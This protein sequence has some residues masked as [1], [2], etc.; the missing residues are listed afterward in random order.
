MGNTSSTLQPNT[1]FKQYR[2]PH[3]RPGQQ[4]IPASLQNPASRHSRCSK[5]ARASGLAGTERANTHSRSTRNTPRNFA[6][7][8]G[9]AVERQRWKA[10]HLRPRFC[11]RASWSCASRSYE[12]TRTTERGTHLRFCG[13]LMWVGAPSVS[14]WGLVCVSQAILSRICTARGQIAVARSS[15][16]FPK[17]LGTSVSYGAWCES[18]AHPNSKWSQSGDTCGLRD[19]HGVERASSEE[20]GREARGFVG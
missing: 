1:Q 8:R 11:E 12:Y 2:Q 20:Q 4:T 10:A 3:T 7:L 18:A 15:E 6:A 5:Q 17:A 16:I 9:K 14:G 13:P 19:I